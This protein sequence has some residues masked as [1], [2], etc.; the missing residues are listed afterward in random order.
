MGTGVLAIEAQLG[1]KQNRS[2]H[3]YFLLLPSPLPIQEQNRNSNQ[4]QL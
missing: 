1:N 4:S 3:D 2:S